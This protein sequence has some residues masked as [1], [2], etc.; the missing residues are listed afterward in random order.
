MNKCEKSLSEE[1]SGRQ[2]KNQSFSSS[3]LDEI[4]RSITDGKEDR[5]ELHF[6]R[7]TMV[8]KHSLRGSRGVVEEQVAGVGGAAATNKW[9]EKK[10]GDKVMSRHQRR[11]LLEFDRKWQHY[12]DPLFFS[13]SSC[14]SDS[15]YGGF[16]S[17]ETESMKSFFAPPS[18]PRQIRTSRS[19]ISEQV[20]RYGQSESHMFDDYHRHHSAEA[21][22]S[23]EEALKSKS[24]ALKIYGSL[25]KVKQPISPGGRLA[26]FLNSLFTAG[27]TKKSTKTAPSAGGLE[28]WSSERKITSQPSTC[29]SASSFARSCLSKNSPSLKEKPR[30]GANRT[31]RFF[32]VSI[33]V[34]EDC[35]PCGHKC[36]YAEEGSNQML[37]SRKITKRNEDDH[38]FQDKTRRVESAGRESHRGFRQK[39]NDNIFNKFHVNYEEEEDEDEDDD[40]A[41]CASSDLFELDHLAL[42]GKGRYQEELP[43]YETTH[44]DT[45]RAIAKGLLV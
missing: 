7:E 27:N 43:V 4:Y 6:Y 13:S 33:I 14:S 15:S 34:D 32:P 30:I 36:L 10:G 42:I 20:S 38:K 29:S 31:V 25:K 45:N 37:A 21:L 22:R 39:K 16:S 26:T 1:K 18:K 5:E 8:K 3:L 24:K 28:D 19:E 41:S 23:E 17:S 11:S 2:R 35:R 40:A 9:M 12:Q 44:I